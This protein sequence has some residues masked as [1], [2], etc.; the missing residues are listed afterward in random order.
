MERHPH[1]YLELERYLGLKLLSLIVQVT[2][3]AK[4]RPRLVLEEGIVQDL[5]VYV[6]LPHLGLHLVLLFLPQLLVLL[7]LTRTFWVSETPY[8]QNNNCTS[9]YM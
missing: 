1:C 6:Q 9:A 5:V 3:D 2:H 7:L 4:F 8:T